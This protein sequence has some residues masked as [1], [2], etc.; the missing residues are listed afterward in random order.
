M[1]NN[2]VKGTAKIFGVIGNP[3][4][5]S[6]SPTI[7]NTMAQILNKDMIYVPFKVNNDDLSDAIKGA[8]ALNIMGLN[9]TVPHK[10][11]VMKELCYI[12]KAA[13]VIG[14]VNTLKYTEKGYEGYNTDVIGVYYAIKNAGYSVENKKVLLLG[15]GGAANACGVMAADK[16]CK[17]L[18]IA[19]RTIEKARAL[20][21]R[22]S[23]NYNCKVTPVSMA[24][25]YDINS[26]DIIIN[27]T[28][29]GFGEKEGISPIENTNFYKDKGVELVFDAIYTPW[30][31]KLL[32]DA[33][34]CGINII[35]GF[36]MLVYQAVAAEE[37]WFN[38][39]Y[40]DNLK[41]R[42]CLELG[43]FYKKEKQ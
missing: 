19:N 27:A 15:A 1:V 31:T 41:E 36:T 6:F 43:D 30:E 24:D 8:Y 16:G 35:N 34:E 38:E 14:A 23:D 5:H 26:C 32:K 42:L 2:S 11:E 4:H 18:F 17:E 9:V 10:V 39:K 28:T 12:D 3:I 21:K 20:A 33:R 25:I 22:I 13:K 29:L 40:D 37:I 7:H